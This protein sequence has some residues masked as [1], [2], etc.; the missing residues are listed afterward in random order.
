[1]TS[2]L[3]DNMPAIVRAQIE[4]EDA[5]EL[6][7]FRLVGCQGL[8][9]EEGVAARAV[10]DAGKRLEAWGFDEPDA[11]WRLARVASGKSA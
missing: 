9:P 11:L 1:M 6:R 10:N 4:A 7:G 5:L 8:G 3:A 2:Q